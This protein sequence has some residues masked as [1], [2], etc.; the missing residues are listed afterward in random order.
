LHRQHFPSSFNLNYINY[1]ILGASLFKGNIKKKHRGLHSWHQV[2][3]EDPFLYYF[4]NG[5]SAIVRLEKSN[6][7]CSSEKPFFLTSKYFLFNFN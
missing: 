1:L 7:T 4:P 6:F 5:P 2:K 3:N